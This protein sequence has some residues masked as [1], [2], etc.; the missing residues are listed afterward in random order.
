MIYT[1]ILRHIRTG[2]THYISSFTPLIIGQK[3]G[4]GFDEVTQDI[5][6]YEV[7]KEL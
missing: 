7:I 3:I 2:K 4:W 5:A 6:Y 1:Y